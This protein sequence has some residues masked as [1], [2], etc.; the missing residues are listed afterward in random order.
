[1]IKPRPLKPGSTV[2]V[3]APSN[4]IDIEDVRRSARI[5]KKWGLKVRYGRNVSSQIEDFCAGTA[6]ERIEDLTRMLR[7]D[8]VE[9]IWAIDGGYAATEVLPMFTQEVIELVRQNPKLFIGYSDIC[10]ILN[11]LTSVG[12][13]SLMAPNVWGLC[14]WD[15]ETHELVRKTLFGEEMTGLP[16]TLGWRSAIAGEAEG[17]IVVSNI[18][19]LIF[20]LGTWFDPFSAVSGDIILGLEDLDIEKS[21]LQ[22]QIDAILNHREAKRIKGMFFGRLTNIVEKTYRRWGQTKTPQGLITERVRK[23]GV[24]LAFCEDFGHPEWEYPPF[25]SLKKYFYNRRFVPIPNGIR[26]RLTSSE[27]SCELRYLEPLTSY[28]QSKDSRSIGGGSKDCAQG[29]GAIPRAAS[30]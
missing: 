2:G 28:C 16:S 17:T 4:A 11:A 13:A 5:I 29:E 6:E 30:L 9:A 24:P 18:D 27:K 25:A 22:R 12:V 10:L 8:E 1:M 19:S 23:F 21:L 3:V 7:D 14:D 20:S 15:K 26:A